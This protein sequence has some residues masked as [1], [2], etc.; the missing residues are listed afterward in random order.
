MIGFNHFRQVN[1]NLDLNGPT[2][3]TQKT[4]SVAKG[5]ETSFTISP[6]LPDGST[7]I[8]LSALTSDFSNFASST[9]Y[10]LTANGTFTLTMELDGAA[11]GVGGSQNFGT[12]GKGGNTRG[13][14][15]FESG[16]TYKLVLG[17]KGAFNAGAGAVGGGGASSGFGGGSGGGFTGI[18][19]TSISQENALLI[20]G[21]GGGGSEQDDPDDG[22]SRFKKANGGDG[23]GLSGGY[24][25]PG[26]TATLYNW[27]SGVQTSGWFSSNLSSFMF[28]GRLDR[29]SK[30]ETSGRLVDF[31]GWS[32][33]G[34]L[35]I[36]EGPVEIWIAYAQYGG[37]TFTVNGE[38]V[39]PDTTGSEGEGAWVKIS[40]GPVSS[41]RATAIRAGLNVQI[42]GVKSNGVLLQTDVPYV[43]GDP[44]AKINIRTYSV[45]GSGGTQLSG[46]GGG[47]TNFIDYKGG[48]GTALLG[49]AGSTFNSTGGGGGGYF[50]GGGGGYVASTINGSGGGGSGFFATTNVVNAYFNVATNTGGGVVKII[51]GSANNR[52]QKITGIATA[53]FPEGQ[54][55][56]NTNTGNIIYNWYEEGV[57]PLSDGT[58]IVGTAT[59]ILSILNTSFADNGRKFFL[60]ANYENSAYFKTGIAKSTANAVNEPFDSE[61]FILGAPPSISIISQPTNSS[62]N[63]NIDT[64]FSVTTKIQSNEDDKTTFDWHYNGESL[65]SLSGLSNLTSS[66]INTFSIDGASSNLTIRNS[67][68]E[69]SKISCVITNTTA[70]PSTISTEEVNFDVSATNRLLFERY[71]SS[72]AGSKTTVVETGQR[73]LGKMGALSFRANSVVENRLVCM[74]A[75]DEDIDVKIT[76]GAAAGASRNGNRGGHGGTSVFKTTL[77][78]GDE[79]IIKLGVNYNQGGGPRGGV[80]GGGGIAAIYRKAKLIAVCGGGGGAGTNG[81]GGDG[82]G[83]A[84]A[85]ENGQGSAAGFGGNTILQG[86]M[87]TYG[88]F[89][90]DG[91]DSIGSGRIS[92]CTIGG[93]WK[94][95]GK[96]PCEDVGLTQY[97]TANGDVNTESFTIQRGF[98]SGTGHRNNGGDATGNQ[99]G[100]GSGGRGGGAATNNGSGGGG[101]SGYASDEVELLNSTVYKTGSISGGNDDVAFISIEAFSETK[102]PSPLIPPNSGTPDTLFRTVFFNTSRNGGDNNTVTFTKQS[103]IGPDTFTFGPSGGGVSA[104]ISSGAVYTRTSFTASGGRGLSFRLG[105]TTDS[106]QLPV[107]E[108]DDNLDNDFD[109]LQV[110][111]DIGGFTSDSRWEAKW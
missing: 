95:Q 66:V 38:S 24:I 10:D 1:T 102:D 51:S 41:F 80:G 75:P 81:R 97:R 58:N 4:I 30:A 25:K 87:P 17:S 56:R 47:S 15:T 99:G 48:D 8:D 94:Q 13:T 92:G 26:G 9:I 79:Y 84:V 28:D 55:S 96:S 91:G 73:D 70:S 101:A 106:K 36:L 108:I 35:P 31:L 90:P 44:R 46:G 64:I 74:Y 42:A 40:D 45:S 68:A 110:Y 49:G 21:G 5:S 37:Y 29:F 33:S 50:G 98:K 53:Q 6:A 104:Q 62:I 39:T 76:L 23:G 18:F 78:K 61:L 34:D 32:N 93:Y 77:K 82:G 11:G 89:P 100:G 109:D 83:L 88:A 85:G 52:S 107:L 59:T 65:N 103:G 67:V 57:G 60:R 86:T 7:S 43:E 3:S 2:L 14:I 19:K 27:K 69:L 63:K 71:G 22:A 16:V 20:A 111:S 72:S 54:L 105:T 12:G